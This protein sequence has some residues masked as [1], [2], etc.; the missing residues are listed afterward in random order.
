MIKKFAPSQLTI[1]SDE[2]KAYDGFVNAD[3]K[4]HYRV[5][6]NE[7]VF[8]NGRTHVNGIENFWEVAKK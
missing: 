2:W 1:Y 6:H 7:E 3:N 5:T 8:A 4:K